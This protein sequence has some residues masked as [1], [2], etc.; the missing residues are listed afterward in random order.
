[1]RK[2]NGSLLAYL[3]PGG[4]FS[5]EVARKY[6][7]GLSFLLKPYPSIEEV[8][9]AVE[10][11]ETDLGIVPIE[12][13][14]EG[15]VNLTLDLLAQD[16]EAKIRGEL[17][18]RVRHFLLVR[19]GQ[20]ADGIEEICS[21]PQAL[22]Q[23]RSFLAETFPG[24]TTRSMTSTAE[25][26]ALVARSKGKAALASRRAAQIYGLQILASD[27]Q[28]EA[29]NVT[30]FLLLALEDALPTGDDKTSLLLGLHDRP[31]SLHSVLG[32]FA[33]SNLNLTKIES[34]PMRSTLGKYIFFL[35]IEGHRHDDIVKQVL[36]NVEKKALFL[37]VLGSYP[38]GRMQ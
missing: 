7:S 33:R 25:A 38:Q 13:S 18:Y 27:T 2:M 21:H 4:T 22:A 29:N 16:R 31:G 5:E 14:L 19:P 35:D 24:I 34:R 30:R 20:D 9:G 26:A 3:G 11:K 37:K 23:C 32:L 10:Q 17:F 28:D 1:M 12:N 6:S 36:I 8:M 15:A